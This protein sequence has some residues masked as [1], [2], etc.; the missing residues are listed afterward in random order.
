MMH[1]PPQHAETY[2]GHAIRIS[3]ATA[4]SAPQ[5][6]A[7]H[8]EWVEQL[9]PQHVFYKLTPDDTSFTDP[10]AAVGHGVRLVHRWIDRML[11]GSTATP[12]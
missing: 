9:T 5:R 4:A 11:A 7:P 3:A 6:F 1:M 2:R 8:I 10:A 12:A